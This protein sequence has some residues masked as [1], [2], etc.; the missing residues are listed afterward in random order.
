MNILFDSQIFTT[1]Q[2]G[3][4][5]RYFVNLAREL[6][7]IEQTKASIFAPFYI[8]QYLHEC[9]NEFRSRG[10]KQHAR[11]KPVSRI[12]ANAATNLALP[13]KKP[14]IIHNTYYYPHHYDK[15]STTSIL[16]VYDMIHE[17][18][19]ENWSKSDKTSKRKYEA[20]MR[21]D[22][23]ICI[24]EK[25][26]SDL[27]NIIDCDPNRVSVVHLGFDTLQSRP[28]SPEVASKIKQFGKYILF[29]G[30]RSGHKNFLSLLKA[31]S[32]NE[33]WRSH[34]KLI[35]FGGGPLNDY[36][37]TLIAN[38]RLSDSV[39]HAQGNDAVLSEFY[40]GASLFVYPSIYEGF[41]IPP[42]EA[43]SVGCPVA[44][45]KI[46]SIPEV[47][48]DAVEYFDPHDAENIALTLDG[49]LSN[50]H[51][52]EQLVTKGFIQANK[53]S[54]SKCSAETLKCYK[55]ASSL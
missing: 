51:K 26:K 45:A 54:W 2:Y 53:F 48:G 47:C 11:L 14:D 43:M 10:I 33:H 42:L 16:T 30:N 34:Y 39:V 3:G 50:S 9:T 31:Y 6:N 52:A 19:P 18:F 44:C 41:G 13:I 1:Q 28:I 49:L 36:E 24:S 29:V 25:T 23:V 37:T 46:S 32:I 4:I 21:S 27:L 12:L 35:C 55:L 40:R 7:N 5:S 8:N 22:H 15:R 38:L 17:L 20:V